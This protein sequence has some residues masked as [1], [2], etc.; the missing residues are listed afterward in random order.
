MERDEVFNFDGLVVKVLCFI[1][2]DVLRLDPLHPCEE[3]GVVGL[4][5]GGVV[6]VLLVSVE[7]VGSG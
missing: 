4:T 2:R 5:E 1:T 7:G 6:V 3:E